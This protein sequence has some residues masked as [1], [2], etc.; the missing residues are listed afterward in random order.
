MSRYL[1]HTRTLSLIYYSACLNGYRKKNRNDFHILCA[2]LPPSIWWCRNFATLI[3]IVFQI[4]LNYYRLPSTFLFL[5]RILCASNF[6]VLHFGGGGV[7]FFFFSRFS[8]I[9]QCIII[10]KLSNLML[11]HF[12]LSPLTVSISNAFQSRHAHAFIK[13]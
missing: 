11:A 12:S 1:I 10:S 7:F 9:F 6:V 13:I 4:T 2:S 5:I 3:L 8:S